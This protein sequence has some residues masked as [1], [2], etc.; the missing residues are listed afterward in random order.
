MAQAGPWS[1]AS[2]GQ[3]MPVDSH[4]SDDDGDENR[5]KA[6]SR[7][8][9]DYEEGENNEY[10]DEWEPRP[11]DEDV[12]ASSSDKSTIEQSDRIMTDIPLSD[13]S[14][15][16]VVSDGIQYY[17]LIHSVSL[18]E[19][20]GEV[21]DELWRQVVEIDDTPES[22][23]PEARV[24]DARKSTLVD[25]STIT[26]IRSDWEYKNVW[27]HVTQLKQAGVIDETRELS[28]ARN[29]ILHVDGDVLRY[30]SRE[31]YETHD[32]ERLR[33]VLKYIG[34]RSKLGEQ[35]G[36]TF[37]RDVPSR[38]AWLYADIRRHMTPVD[39]S[40]DPEVRF[41]FHHFGKADED[42]EHWNEFPYEVLF[43]GMGDMFNEFVVF[44]DIEYRNLRV[45][46]VDMLERS[47]TNTVVG[48]LGD[49]Q[50]QEN[51]GGVTS[52][53]ALDAAEEVLEE[54]GGEASGGEYYEP[55]VDYDVLV[56][57]DKCLIRI[58]GYL[59]EK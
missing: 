55:K 58:L 47:L 50:F 43:G 16:P 21:V 24:S 29:R 36:L 45:L 17:D 56:D 11:I 6:E 14:F 12:S 42:F 13:V 20:I 54:A 23:P 32:N 7:P 44:V 30:L 41:N 4:P 8:T 28:D 27:P 10:G 1:S 18:D 59:R 15:L 35:L 48:Y 52:A 51:V 34:S 22:D 31:H 25:F 19:D 5:D 26:G 3:P 40:A 39:P 38:E 49:A 2:G 37:D 9:D 53:D 46:N 57:T 33:N